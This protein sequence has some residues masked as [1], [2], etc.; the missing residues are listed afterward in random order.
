MQNK[1]HKTP[2]FSYIFT[3][4]ANTTIKPMIC[5]SCSLNNDQQNKIKHMLLNHFHNKCKNNN[6]TYV[7]P[8]TSVGPSCW[9]SFSNDFPMIFTAFPNVF[10]TCSKHF[11]PFSK[12]FRNI[13]DRFSKHCHTMFERFSNVFEAFSNHFRTIFKA[14]SNVFEELSKHFQM[15]FGACSN[16][17]RTIFERV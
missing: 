13:S 1:K 10:E 6:T 9:R 11:Q 16:D 7:F 14:F 4:D 17:V 5:Q 2:D 15:I 3:K 12:H 8:W